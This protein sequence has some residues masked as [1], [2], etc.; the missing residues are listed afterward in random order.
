MR[1]GSG[2]DGGGYVLVRGAAAGPDAARGLPEA[3]A[4]WFDGRDGGDRGRKW[5]RGVLGRRWR[6]AV[7]RGAAG[8]AAGAGGGRAVVLGVPEAGAWRFEGQQGLE[9]D[10]RW[11]GR[12]QRRVRG[13]SSSR[14]GCDRGR[15]RV[16]G[17]LGPP[18]V[19]AW[20]FE[21]PR[22]GRRG[23]EAGAGRFGGRRKRV[24]GRSRGWGRADRGRKWVRGVIG[25]PEAGAGSFERRRQG[26]WGPEA[27]AGV[28]EARGVVVGCSR[29]KRGRGYYPR[30]APM[31]IAGCTGA[32]T[33]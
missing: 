10:V 30:G 1:G 13:C 9:A 2:R 7:V 8:G 12:R 26:R 33:G 28:R 23:A 6:V 32:S 21:G 14:G 17:V 25:A 20:R 29:D 15:M 27:G 16:R 5:V 24:H 3:G 22:Q 31:Q 19:G 4:R 18:R 11:F